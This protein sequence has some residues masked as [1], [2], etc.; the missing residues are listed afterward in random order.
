MATPPPREEFFSPAHDEIMAYEKKHFRSLGE[1]LQAIARVET[2]GSDSRLTRA[3]TGAGEVDPTGGGFLVQ[4]GF[5]QEL[6]ESIYAGAVLAPLCDRRKTSKLG[7]TKIP[8]IDESSRGDGSRAGGSLAFWKSETDSISATFPRFR[9]IEFGPHTLIAV[10][11]AS[12]ELMADVPMLDAH[13][14]SVFKSEL[15]FQ[16]DRAILSGTGAGQPLGLLNSAAAIV[17][18]KDTGQTPATIPVTN[19]VN[20]LSRLPAPSRQRATWIVNEDAMG[21]LDSGSTFTGI[22][23]PRGAQG[24]TSPI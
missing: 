12:R 8:A 14:R 21:Q 3:P 4:V 15:S 13:M 24:N 20:M 22:F 2:V 5:V 1:Q 9:S 17:V 7:G 16:L 18:P 6:I 10:A 19:V 11:V 23:M